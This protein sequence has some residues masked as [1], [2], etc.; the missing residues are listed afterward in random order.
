MIPPMT[1]PKTS[2][3]KSRVGGVLY[4]T[5]AVAWL[6][7]GMV[8]LYLKQAELFVGLDGGYMRNLAQRQFE[9]GL[10]LSSASMDWF[11]GLGDVYFAVNF[12]LLPSFIAGSLFGSTALA[13]I[14]TY[15]VILAELSLAV[16]LFGRSLGASLAVSIAAAL[17]TC[18]TVL[19][20]YHP[21]LIYA[22]LPLIPHIGSVIAGAL[23]AGAAFLQFGRRSLISDLPFALVV[24]A[25]L[26]WSTLVSVTIIMLAAP[27][28]LLCCISGIVAAT[29]PSER[30]CKIFLSV[31][32]ALFFATAGPAAYF[33][34]TVLDT[35]AIVFPE[36]LANNRA[37]FYF[38]S[39]LFH[40]YTVGPVGPLLVVF[41][42]VGAALEAFDRSHRTLRIFAITLLTYLGTR[43]TFAVL[44]IAFDFWRGPGAVYFEYYVIPL[45]AI[46][47]ALLFSRVFGGL[48]RLL[49]WS[50]PSRRSLEIGLVTAAI[51][52]MLA[53]AAGNSKNDYGFPFPPKATAITDILAQETGL[54][55]GTIFRGRTA[56]VTG[57]SI[58]GDVDWL[59]LHTNDYHLELSAGN[60]MRLVGLNY[61]GIPSLF[62]Y[63]PTISPFF[64]AV[65]SRLLALPADKQMRNVMVLRE[66]DPRILAMLGVRFV[67]TDRKYEGPVSVRAVEPTKE[68]TLFLYEIAKPGL[69]DYSP[70]AV[71]KIATA[72][73]IVA[74]LADPQFDPTHE[75][76]ADVPGDVNGLVPAHNAYLT[77]GGGSLRLH[78][79]SDGRSIVLVP[80]EFSRCLETR[81][82]E[83]E[84]P[85][86]FRANLVETGVLFS[87]RLD[88]TLSLRTGPFLNPTCRLR[89][90]F[91]ARALQIGKVPP[92]SMHTQS[93]AQ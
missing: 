35:A 85:L 91:E 43:L 37:S 16:V 79:E 64:Y 12:R 31:A 80:L 13:K 57:R 82:L 36:E 66:I 74:R 60:E 9:W 32:V 24:F 23:M 40:W 7:A 49:N 48:W 52:T 67:L 87:G 53:L 30:R 88:T 47:A 29:T 61:F 90:F 11:Q 84:K 78:A 44:V 63:T 76:I 62:E 19:P 17:T 73:Q 71:S 56:N 51:V 15:E 83:N 93:P 4:V 75:V 27:F 54:R 25:L 55:P 3:T 39:I 28:L 6:A 21:T 33:L 86:L 70:T 20:F 77:F 92:R 69:G 65:T 22:L 68:G 41:A 34:G 81:A 50:T 26:I 18:I 5:L 10:A 38:A 2:D 14:V 46:F 45:Y 8:A 59:D 72:P 42:V 89:D 58:D 1:E